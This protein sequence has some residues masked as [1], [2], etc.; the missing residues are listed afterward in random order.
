MK[1]RVIVPFHYAADGVR[2]NLLKAGRFYDFTPEHAARFEG[3]GLLEPAIGIGAMAQ[4][5]P[6]G[7]VAMTGPVTGVDGD[8]V[9]IG[10]S[11]IALPVEEV[12]RAP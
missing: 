8:F 10:D 11:D 7:V 6:G 12:R 5:V 4:W 1:R 2:P 3:E 9:N